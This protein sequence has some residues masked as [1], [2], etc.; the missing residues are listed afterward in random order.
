MLIELVGCLFENCFEDGICFDWDKMCYFGMW[1]GIFCGG[2]FIVMLM[3]Y[4][5]KG[6]IIV[7]ILFVSIILW[8]CGISVIYFFYI[9]VGDDFFN[10]FKQVV[11]FY[12]IGKIFNVQEWNIGDYGGQFGFV[13]VMFFYVDIMDCM[14]ILYGMVCF[15]NFIDFVIQ[16][17]EGLFVVYMVDVLSIFIGVVFGVFFVIVFVEFGVGI[18]E[19]GK[20]GFIVMVVGFCF[21]I[22]VFFVFI[23]VFIF[24]WVIGCVLILVG[25]MMVSVVI[26]I[27]WKYM[28]DVVFVFFIIVFMFF[29]YFIVD[30]LIVGICI[31]IFINILVWVIKKVF[32]GWIV[33]FNYEERDFWMWCIFGGFFLLWIVCFFCGKKDFWWEDELVVIEIVGEQDFKIVGKLSSLDNGGLEGGREIFEIVIS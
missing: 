3:F 21:F 25:V 6:V 10:F 22:L 27:N 16:D 14:G 12:F 9:I 5:V 7:G 23:F 30:G 17:F 20:I 33:L 31:Y 24:L 26:E 18:F 4:W 19:G 15:V 2:I 1:I 13:L 32:G 28:G 8:F 29:I 11:D